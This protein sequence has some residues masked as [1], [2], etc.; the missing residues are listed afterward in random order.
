MISY[1]VYKIIH[2][3]GVMMVFMSIGGLATNAI[4]RREQGQDWRRGLAVTHGI[5]MVLSLVAGFGLLARLGVVHGSLP[6]WVWAKLLIWGIFGLMSA[7][8]MRKPSSGKWLW[9]GSLV[10]GG[11]AA[12]LAG[13]KPF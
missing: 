7:V 10:L 1:G 2:L 9:M 5:G 4:I 8:L 3:L 12:Y 13:Q 11:L 6:I